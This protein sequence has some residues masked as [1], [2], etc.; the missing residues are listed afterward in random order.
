MAGNLRLAPGLNT[1]T[2]PLKA[3]TSSAACASPWSVRT[4]LR[5]SFTDN[6]ILRD[7]QTECLAAIE[8][9]W[10]KFSRQLIVMA[11][12]TGKTV[13]FARIAQR[14]VEAG[15]K[16]L[17]LAHTEELLDQAIDKI[18]RTTGIEADKE[19]ADNM[20]SPHASIVVA[21]VQT[22]SRLNRLTSFADSHFSL[23][24]CDESHRSLAKSYQKILN[25]FHFGDC[26]LAEGWTAPLP[27]VPYQH[28]ARIL[29]VTATPSRSDRRSLGEFYQTCAY[30]YGLLDACREGYLIRPIIENIPLQLDIR[31]VKKTSSD[32]DSTEVAHKIAPF[33]GKIA[34]L[35]APKIISRKTAVFMPS[36][37]T[38]RLM[39]DALISVGIDAS[40]ISGACT[41]RNEKLVSFH[42]KGN[43][44]AIVGAMLLAEGW[45]HPPVSAIV[46]LRATKIQSLLQQIVGRGTRPLA[47]V[48]DGLNT[49]E[50]RLAAIAASEKK[51][52]VVFDFLWLSD[53]VDLISPVDLVAGSP[54]IKKAMLKSGIKDVVAAEAEAQKDLLKS[55]AKAAAKH[56]HRQPRTID[57][58]AWAVSLGDAVLDGYSPQTT[59]EGQAATKEELDFILNAGLDSSRIKTSGAAQKIINRIVDRDKMGLATVK[60]LN[61]LAKLGIPEERAVLMKKGQAGAIIGRGFRH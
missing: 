42:G 41:D 28:K 24:I 18:V 55:L 16:V 14:E 12:G 5:L 34:E 26:A 35:L 22:L 59:A 13:C 33:L 50:E 51:D 45:D 61:F 7:Y 44:S 25:R 23:V 40:F 29:G 39:A 49:A 2:Q 4:G 46:P 19:K 43:G 48:I 30:E 1:A 27:S 10:Q 8:T 6:V 60:Q 21:S 9:G 20:A 37:E 11:T 15:G 56:Q 47:G 31:G 53:S 17:I 3:T 54:E 38:A 52:L 32:Y 36:I 57:P 58:I